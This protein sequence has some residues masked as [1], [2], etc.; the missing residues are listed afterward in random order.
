[1]MELRQLHYFVA[2]A[3]EANFTRAAARVRVAQPAV[4]QQ[5]GLLERELGEK[6]FDRS[7][8][9]IRLTPAGE[10]FLPYARAALDATADGRDAVTSIGGELTGL[11][12]IATIPVPPPWLLVR[13]ADFRRRYPKVRHAVRTGDPDDL[14]AD[15]AA[16]ALDAAVIG[17]M[18]RRLPAG[19][20]GRRLPATLA[21]ATVATEPL[22]IAVAR[23][24]PLAGATEVHLSELRLEPMVSLTAGAG[25]RTVLENACAEVGYVPDIR[26]ETD[27]LHLLADLAAHGLGAALMPRSA[28]ERARPDLAILPLRTPVLNR[29]MTLIWH[30]TSQ[31]APARAFLELADVRDDPIRK[32]NRPAAATPTADTR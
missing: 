7:D 24:H 2:V 13:L 14:A 29:R 3:Q 1:M 23:D 10:A 4:S 28:A 26:A 27:D 6:L 25:L 11:L 8:R 21:T 17:V 30:R 16:G 32:P 5:I 22:V 12:R 15:V 19:P 18:S 20:G 31:S 9:R